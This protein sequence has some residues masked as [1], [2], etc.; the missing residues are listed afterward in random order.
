M[1]EADNV[2]D[3]LAELRV[4]HAADLFQLSQVVNKIN[5]WH[6]SRSV[7]G[8]CSEGKRVTQRRHCRRVHSRSDRDSLMCSLRHPKSNYS[9]S[10]K[11][12][13]CPPVVACVSLSMDPVPVCYAGGGLQCRRS[14][15]QENQTQKTDRV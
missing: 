15:N 5:A 12:F 6:R 7:S 9:I 8:S 2:T 1:V 10:S 4:L 3:S 14:N 13:L 11:M